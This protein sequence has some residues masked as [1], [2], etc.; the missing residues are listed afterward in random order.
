[1]A[2]FNRKNSN[3]PTIAPEL[4]NYYETEKRDRTWMAWL[5]GFITLVVTILLAMAI[6]FGGRWVYR[7]LVST[8]PNSN[9]SQTD[10]GLKNISTPSPPDTD[11]GTNTTP[12]T[13]PT[14]PTDSSRNEN[15]PVATPGSNAANLPST[16]PADTIVIFA[17]VSVIA[18][19]SHRRFSTN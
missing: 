15:Q 5:L 6:Y 12:A 16:G 19:I 2:L 3:Q 11:P 18:Y 8:S 13:S 10:N 4:Q 1:M 14:E 17:V 9:T 7:K